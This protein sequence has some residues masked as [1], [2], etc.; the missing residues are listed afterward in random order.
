M[1][2]SRKKRSFRQRSNTKEVL[3][4]FADNIGDHDVEIKVFAKKPGLKNH[5]IR[6]VR[7]GARRG[8]DLVQEGRFTKLKDFG[9]K[10]L[11][12]GRGDLRL[13]IT[14]TSMMSHQGSKP[15]AS[16]DRA[17]LF[18]SSQSSLDEVKKNLEKFIRAK[19]T[20]P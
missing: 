5:L 4:H 19:K 12:P 15:S 14:M 16:D 20:S 2:R 9:D 11:G 18:F 1:R 3:Y 13:A 8:R 7:K 17:V 6:V 10:P